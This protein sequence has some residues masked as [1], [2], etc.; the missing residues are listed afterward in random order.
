MLTEPGGQLASIDS[1]GGQIQHDAL[2]IVQAG[3]KVQGVQHQKR[4]HGGMAD[5]LVA[6]EERMVSD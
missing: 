1:T 3:I 2:L 4:L 5:A 6:V